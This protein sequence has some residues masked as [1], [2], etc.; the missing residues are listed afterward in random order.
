MAD[1]IELKGNEEISRDFETPGALTG[2]QSHNIDALPDVSQSNGRYRALIDDNSNNK[3]L[4]YHESQGRLDAVMVEFPFEVVARNIGIGQPDDSQTP[5]SS[6][7]QPFL[8]AGIQ[9]HVIDSNQPNSAHLV[10]GHRGETPLTVEAKSTRKGTSTVNDDGAGIVPQGR[11]DLK[12]VGTANRRLQAYWQTPNPDPATVSDQ[13]N[14][15]GGNGKFPG[16]RKPKF[17]QQVLV[18]LIT[19]AYNDAGLP[20]VGTCDGFYV[21]TPEGD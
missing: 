16:F 21:T 9:V 15:Y 19:Y 18:G 17:G 13:W 12:I 7:R 3:T 20:F 2:F 10:V 6:D 11:A 1:P 5:P 4:H 8:F 14:A